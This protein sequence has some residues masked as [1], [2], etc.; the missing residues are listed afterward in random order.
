MAFN[1]SGAS[2]LS[3]AAPASQAGA[4]QVAEIVRALVRGELGNPFRR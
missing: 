1:Q 2:L 4:S 3:I